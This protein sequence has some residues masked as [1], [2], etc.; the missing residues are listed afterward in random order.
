MADKSSSALLLGFGFSPVFRK[1][2]SKQIEK[3][4]EGYRKSPFLS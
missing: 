4:R 1:N 3:P 2:G